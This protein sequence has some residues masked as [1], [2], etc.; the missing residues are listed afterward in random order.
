MKRSAADERFTNGNEPKRWLGRVSHGTETLA[1]SGLGI[2]REVQRTERALRE[3]DRA[4]TASQRPSRVEVPWCQTYTYKDEIGRVTVRGRNWRYSK[5]VYK[6][7][8]RTP[9][10]KLT[11]GMPGVYAPGNYHD[12]PKYRFKYEEVG[13]LDE[14]PMPYPTDVNTGGLA[15]ELQNRYLYVSQTDE[16]LAQFLTGG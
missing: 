4:L 15:E 13:E 11:T 2:V 3:N 12:P 10:P 5:P 7:V 14:D 8:H 1:E 16:R 9:P 6:T